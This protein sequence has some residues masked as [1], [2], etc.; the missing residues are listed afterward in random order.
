MVR[1]PLSEVGFW[2]LSSSESTATLLRIHIRK[3]R[4]NAYDLPKALSPAAF[5]PL[6]HLLR[7]PDFWPTVKPGLSFD[8]ERSVRQKPE[9]VFSRA[10][11]LLEHCD[12]HAYEGWCD[13]LPQAM[14]RMLSK[15]DNLTYH[16]RNQSQPRQ[17]DQRRRYLH[18]SEPPRLA[19][20]PG[21]RQL[22]YG[23]SLYKTEERF[24]GCSLLSLLPTKW[25]YNSV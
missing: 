20:H 7:G 3:R 4:G 10:P 11:Q 8:P 1:G 13:P 15:L 18:P 21:S 2:K 17:M 5:A 22:F 24:M 25:L 9:H 16:R 19:P 6:R 12:G 23:R 14:R